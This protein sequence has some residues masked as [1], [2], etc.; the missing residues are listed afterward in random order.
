MP[1]LNGSF[2]DGKVTVLVADATRMDCQ[3]MS[4]AIQRHSRFRVIG[5]VTR[6]S[7]VVSSLRSSPPDVA[8]ISA[9]LQ[10]GSSA[11]L[12]VLQELRA[13]SS[14]PRIVMLLDNDERQL[15]VESF[16]NGARGIF[17]KV[18]SSGELRKCLQTIHNGEI[19]ISNAQVEYIVDALMQTPGLRAVND[20]QA[21]LL[22]RREDE[23]ARHVATG[24]SN[25]EVSE[26]LG[27]SPHTVK[28]YLFRIFE[29]LGISTRIELVLYILSQS[30]PSDSD[31]DLAPTLAYENPIRILRDSTHRSVRRAEAKS[32]RMFS[33]NQKLIS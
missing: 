16:L 8:V 9:R 29:K 1:R 27:L 24:L 33:T 18:G 3:L 22:S 20:P 11:G 6:S 32:M 2:G 19:W 13:M 10:D 17:C 25:L 21:S 26:K 23:I 31:R 5:N 15:V 7:E 12:S 30:R 14:R 4:D 28:N